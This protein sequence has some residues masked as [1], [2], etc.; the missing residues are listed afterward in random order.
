M[1]DVTENVTPAPQI[2][3]TPNPQISG[4]QGEQSLGQA[5][6][7]SA[8]LDAILASPEFEKL[9]EKKVQSK[10]DKR[11]GQY[12]TRLESLEDAVSQYEA[13]KEGGLSSAEALNQMRGQQTLAEMK[14][15]IEALKGSVMAG[16]S[17]GAGAQTWEEAQQAIL[18]KHGLETTDPRA[19]ELAR[20][21][22]WKSHKEYLDAL[23]EK[24]NDWSFSDSTKPKPSTSTVANTT[25]AAVP[26]GDAMAAYQAELKAIPRGNVSAIAKLKK[27]Y[28]DEHGLEVW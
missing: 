17:A 2:E 4:A 19:V 28:R 7:K 6:D 10:Q 9:V 16:G 27:K 3:E 14:A 1:A 25:P 15:E 13:L 12:G 11:L 24:A 8:I 21:K 5:G 26:S 18:S 22:V 23:A 20:S